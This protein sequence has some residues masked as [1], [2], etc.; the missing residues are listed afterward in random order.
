M[1][2]VL[3]VQPN[4]EVTEL[5][6]KLR[7]D[8][9]SGDITLVVPQGSRLAQS[10]VNV[11]LLGRYA[12]QAGRP[13]AIISA[14][15]RVLAAATAA[16]MRSFE[17]PE[18]YYAATGEYAAEPVVAKPSAREVHGPGSAGL[19]AAAATA[20][21]ATETASVGHVFTAAQAAPAR[22]TVAPS[23]G[24]PHGGAAVP[25]S[26][27]PQSK[28]STAALGD[29]GKGRLYILAGAILVLGVLLFAIFGSTAT[30][31]ATIN[32]TPVSVNS[33]IQGSASSSTASTPG[34]VLTRVLSASQSQVITAKPTGTKL[35]PAVAA[36][37]NVELETSIPAP[38]TVSVTVPQGSIFETSDN[39]PV[40]FVVTQTTVAVMQGPPAGSPNT[41]YGAPSNPIPVQAQVPGTTGNVVAGAI[42]QWPDNPCNSSGNGNGNGNSVGSS[43]C[44]FPASLLA[45]TNQ[46]ET[47]GGVNAQKVTVFSQA[48]ITSLNSTVSQDETR[49]TAQVV[50]QIKSQ[51]N[52]D[53]L[54]I[55]PG[56]GGEQ[57][58]TTVTPAVPAVGTQ[59]T[60]LSITVNVAGQAAAFNAAALK[61]L[62]RQEL[63][64]KVPKGDMLV[65]N[66]TIPVPAV[67]QASANGIVIFSASASGYDQPRV[68]FAQLKKELAGKSSSAASSLI[69]SA[70]GG[71]LVQSI[72]I[73][74]SPFPFFT[75]PVFS[76]H[77]QINEKVIAS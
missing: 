11:R 17:S 72:I 38:D 52:G 27:P 76:N 5:V 59:S 14:D 47:S 58:T 24:S 28:D 9:G 66:P 65:A 1:A 57:M 12:T 42:N 48:D 73:K 70:M 32:A 26:P 23:P 60:G 7:A 63:V 10:Q 68:N 22:G 21:I 74:E 25:G 61:N 69:R 29:G 36:T 54:A 3:Q 43:G 49:L 19:A 20:T 56:G 67:T 2:T 31:T 64:S 55:D 33:I 15:R 62:V 50:S 35:L 6:E 16:G 13:M 51:A 37:G 41:S 8:R 40:V 39:P 30:V 4:D 34:H 45:A 53:T 46:S 18:E 75:L 71:N 44:Q 77:I